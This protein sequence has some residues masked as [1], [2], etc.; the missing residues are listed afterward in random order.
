[1]AMTAFAPISLEAL[2]EAIP[3]GALLAVPPDYG[4]VAMAATVALLR[5][6]TGG[7]RLYCLPYSTLQADLLI[8]TG[9]VAEVEAAAITL[10]EQ[11]LAPRFSAAVEGGRL[12]MRDSTCPALHAALQAAEK[13]VPF[14]PLRGLLGSDILANR[15]D[16]KVIDNPFEAGDPIVLLPAV[17]PDVALFHAPRAD[18]EGNVWIGR[19]R[20]LATLAHAAK[21]TLVTVEEVVEGSFFESEGSAANALPA[22]YV[23]AVAVAPRGAWPCACPGLYDAD[24]AAIGDYAKAARDEAGFRDYLKR[25]LD[26]RIAPCVLEVEPA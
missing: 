23:E 12:T 26:G 3:D 6:G 11:G 14:M 9:A 1:M 7:L 4:G 20:E 24:P 18:A 16:W 17:V 8:G 5:R 15:P 25:L 19:R 21:R 22:L 10:G 2:A 13:G